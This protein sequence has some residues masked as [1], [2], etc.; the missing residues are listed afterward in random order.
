ML[1]TYIS[2]TPVVQPDPKHEGFRNV[3][4]FLLMLSGLAHS[5]C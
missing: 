3:E 5:S 1:D 4:V 2:G